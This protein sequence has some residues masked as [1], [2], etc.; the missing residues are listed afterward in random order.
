MEL[1]KLERMREAKERMRVEFPYQERPPVT[2]MYR[3]RITVEDFDFGYRRVILHL[4]DSGRIDSYTVVED[5][6]VI[7]WRTGFARVL[8]MLLDRFKRVAAL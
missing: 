5:G 2:P 1:R 4:Y 8:N 6:V 7:S 3:R